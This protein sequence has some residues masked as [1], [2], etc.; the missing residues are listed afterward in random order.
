M[1]AM[2]GHKESTLDKVGGHKSVGIT[3]SIVSGCK[4]RVILLKGELLNMHH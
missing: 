1:Y 2:V 3:K 4:S